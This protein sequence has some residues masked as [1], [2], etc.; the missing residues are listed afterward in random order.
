MRLTRRKECSHANTWYSPAV[1]SIA[2]MLSMLLPWP[3]SPWKVVSYAHLDF[4]LFRVAKGM[5]AL[6][7]EITIGILAGPHVGKLVP[8]ADALMLEGELALVLRLGSKVSSR[9][10]S[11]TNALPAM[12]AM[13]QQS[14]RLGW[15]KVREGV[16]RCCL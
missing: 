5:P 10:R 13:L 12:P 15:L 8:E 2:C 16:A 6:V 11:L 1:R 4:P 7:G 9:F 14:A 3:C